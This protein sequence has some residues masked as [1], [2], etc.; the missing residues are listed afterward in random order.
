MK[1]T[2]SFFFVLVAAT[3]FGQQSESPT[4]QQ[5]EGKTK[6]VSEKRTSINVGVR[7][8][9]GSLAGADFEFLVEKRLGLQLGAGISSFGVG[10]NYHLQPYINSQ[11]VSVQYWHH[12]FGN[13]HFASYLGPMYC[14]RARKILQLGLGLGVRVSDGPKDAGAMKSP[15]LLM[16]NIG[17]YFPL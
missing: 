1:K 9:G 3:C 8:G 15:I 6:F 2:L 4:T 5:V 11:F 16:Y 13:N 14:F 17:I 12:G 7:M 10:I